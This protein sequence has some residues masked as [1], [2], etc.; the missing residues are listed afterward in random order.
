MLGY[1][2]DQALTEDTIKGNFLHTGDLGRID[3]KGRLFIVGRK[4]EII[5]GSNGENVY[6]DE[7]E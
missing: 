6:P 2:N 1:Y 5:I 7:L 4:K 3:D